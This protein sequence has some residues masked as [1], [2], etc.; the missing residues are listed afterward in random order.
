MGIGVEFSCSSCAYSGFGDVGGGRE[1]YHVDLPF[2]IYCR[3]CVDVT[4]ANM[5]SKPLTCTRCKGV[6]VIPYSADGLKKGGTRN[7]ASAFDF[8]L[9]NADHFCPKCEAFA[10]HF[11]ATIYFD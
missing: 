8:E 6:E 7:V 11:E 5:L 3:V 9:T 10:L 4:S 1:D 2:P